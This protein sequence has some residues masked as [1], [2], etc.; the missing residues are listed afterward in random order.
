MPWRIVVLE[1]RQ[2][3]VP[4]RRRLLG[5]HPVRLDLPI[6]AAERSSEAIVG[7]IGSSVMVPSGMVSMVPSELQ[8]ELLQFTAHT[9]LDVPLE[10]DREAEEQQ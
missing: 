5:D 7:D 4:Q 1:W 9:P 2:C 10:Q 8:H 3:L 6:E